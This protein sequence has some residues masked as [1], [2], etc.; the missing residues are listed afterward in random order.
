MGEFGCN[1]CE[2]TNCQQFRK[3]V[4]SNDGDEVCI[5]WHCNDC[6]KRFVTGYEIG[7]LVHYSG[8]DR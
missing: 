6:G 3:P 7:W 4:V 8:G 2:S 1:N 5:Y